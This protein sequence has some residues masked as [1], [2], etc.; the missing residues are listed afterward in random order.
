MEGGGRP[1]HR[2]DR[3]RARRLGRGDLARPELPGR[4]PSRRHL[5][6]FLTLEGIADPPEGD[7]VLVLRRKPGLLDLLRPV[8]SLQRICPGRALGLS[9]FLM[10]RAI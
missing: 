10:L 2:S 3:R 9:Y 1:L 6:A 4:R 5:P 7:L 8:D